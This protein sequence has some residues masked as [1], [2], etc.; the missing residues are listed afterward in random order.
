[1]AP[2][3]EIHLD[4]IV[5]TFAPKDAEL[6]DAL[7]AA[8]EEEG[9]TFDGRGIK[10]FL[11]QALLMEPDEDD[12]VDSPGAQLGRLIVEQGMEFVRKNPHVPSALQKKASTFFKDLKQRF[13][14]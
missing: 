8:L 7:K 9:F 12:E 14:Q 3:A 6:R 4:G 10:E 5:I 11:T 2:K 1:M 13:N